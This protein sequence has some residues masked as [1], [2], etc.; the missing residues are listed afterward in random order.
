MQSIGNLTQRFVLRAQT[1][2]L[3]SELVELSQEVATGQTS[4]KARFLSG[5]FNAIADLQ[6]SLKRLESYR[7]VAA[8]T[9]LALD[10]AGG[11]LSTLYSFSSNLA[12]KLPL[13]SETGTNIAVNAIA[14]EGLQAFQGAVS[15]LNSNTAG[16]SVFGGAQFDQPVLAPSD[17]ILTAVREQ[18]EAVATPAEYIQSLDDWFSAPGGGFETVAYLGSDNFSEPVNVG[19]DV[20]VGFDLKAD[21]SG[22]R[23]VLRDFA[24]IALVADPAFGFSDADK[25]QIFETMLPELA[26]S[27]NTLIDMQ[28]QLGVS[29]EYLETAIATNE[30]GRLATESAIADLL[31]VD[32]FE[33]ATRLENVSTQ[34]EGIYLVTARLN[35]MS[36]MDYLS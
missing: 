29:Q 12:E 28:A 27:R 30:A 18:I 3:K 26:D 15:A 31:S 8:E 19:D 7:L 6:H 32:P 35:Q 1:S 16:R 22:I 24:A 11:A 25:T 34:M 23:K 10:T 9:K 33:T 13:L 20:S 4:D 17:E 14:A 36:L 5:D 2:S 21:Q